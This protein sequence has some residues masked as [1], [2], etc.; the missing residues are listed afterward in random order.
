MPLC[1]NGTRASQPGECCVGLLPGALT[2]IIRTGQVPQ[3]R[4]QVGMAQP[5]LNRADRN[6]SFVMHRRVRL[7]QA[8]ELPITT[9]RMFRAAQI[10]FVVALPAVQ[11]CSQ[12][13]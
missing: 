13:E 8:M 12:S 9:N 10:V 2:F 3:C 4:F 6:T 5:T 1:R 11:A 7:P